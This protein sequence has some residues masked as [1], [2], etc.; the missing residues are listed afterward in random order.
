MRKMKIN[1]CELYLAD[2]NTALNK[3]ENES[4][5]AVIT[6]PP[7]QYLKHKLDKSFDENNVFQNWQRILKNNSLIA[8]FGFGDAFHRW[9]ILLN[10]LRFK[11]KETL[12]WEKTQINNPF[13][14]LA[15]TVEFISI[16][17]KGHA[18]INK[19]LIDFFDHC[20]NNDKLESLKENY[21]HLHSALNNSKDI[22]EIKKYLET[23][24][25]EYST[26][27]KEKPKITISSNTKLASKN[28][29]TL[30]TLK[31]GRRE[32]SIIRCKRDANYASASRR[33][34]TQ[35]KNQSS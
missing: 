9:N 35:R 1:N 20:I 23:G 2:S 22:N 28:I 24:I 17:S 3:F 21:K 14:S 32:T 4:F 27:R 12:V 6:D 33:M 7:Y 26:T 34:N 31:E 25:T 11:F 16:R 29:T 13:S 15:R 8:F 30:K 10:D 5:D 18:T 19:C